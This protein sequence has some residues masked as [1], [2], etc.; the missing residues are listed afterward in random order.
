[1]SG[2]LWI[3]WNRQNYLY[4]GRVDQPLQKLLVQAEQDFID[5]KEIKTPIRPL[6]LCFRRERPKP[7]S[8]PVLTLI[9]CNTSTR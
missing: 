5:G 2:D 7:A 1:M 3:K 9:V 4:V 6:D 8:Q